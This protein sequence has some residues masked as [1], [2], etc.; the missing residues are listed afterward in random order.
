M[1]KQI[2][3]DIFFLSQKS[4]KATKEDLHIAK[5]LVDTLKSHSDECVGMAANMIGYKK[6]IIAVSIG[7]MI[8]VMI[9]PIITKKSN[10]YSTNEGCLS[11]DGERPCERYKTIE[12]EF[13]DI[14]FKHK[15]QSFSEFTAE[16][17]QH[18]ID[19]CNG[20]VI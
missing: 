18:E 4:E 5:D 14:N 15:K 16:I 12:V 20:I 19:H 3:K 10:K 6:Q 17:I 2:V 13:Y 1:E 9:N 11:L 7:P 8:L